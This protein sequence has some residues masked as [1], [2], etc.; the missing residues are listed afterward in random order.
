MIECSLFPSF[1][2]PFAKCHRPGALHSRICARTK[3]AKTLYGKSKPKTTRVKEKEKEGK[4]EGEREGGKDR[5]TDRGKMKLGNIKQCDPRL[6][7]SSPLYNKP[8][9]D[10]GFQG[11][12]ALSVVHGA[13]KEGEFI[14]LPVSCL[15]LIKVHST[16]NSLTCIS[17]ARVE[18][19][20]CVDGPLTKKEKEGTSHRNLR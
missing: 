2:S 4:G 16:K 8:Q 7:C 13:R 11:T 10:R 14:C 15:P 17:A 12:A 1:A 5:Q 19:Q 20:P 9:R 3:G 18:G 6:L